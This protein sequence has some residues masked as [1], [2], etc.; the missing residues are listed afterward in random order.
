MWQPE[1]MPETAVGMKTCATEQK[2]RSGIQFM[3]TTCTLRQSGRY[4]GNTFRD[5]LG[6]LSCSL[7]VAQGWFQS[8]IGF[9]THLPRPLWML[10]VLLSI[11]KALDTNV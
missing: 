1:A 9:V 10:H 3:M 5:V 6:N 8:S 4:L 11:Q 7:D 2:P